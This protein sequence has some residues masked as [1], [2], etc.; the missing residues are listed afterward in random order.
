MHRSTAMALRMPFMKKEEEQEGG[1]GGRGRQG[2]CLDPFS[3]VS[4]CL[5]QSLYP[6]AWLMFISWLGV[7]LCPAGRV[8]V[9]LCSSCKSTEGDGGG[10]G[11]SAPAD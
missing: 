10:D 4:Q 1:G 2:E 8:G 11:G 3:P 6:R 7:S 9:H 5:A